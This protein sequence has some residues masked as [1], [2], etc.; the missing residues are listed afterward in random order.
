LNEEL[1]DALEARRGI[2]CAV[3]AGGKKS[4]LYRLAQGHPG[5]VGLTASAHTTFFP[6]TLGLHE[7]I[8]EPAKLAA[9]VAA[10][11][12]QKIGY[13]TPSTRPGRHAGV[14]VE[15]IEHLH[16]FGGFDVTLVKADG[17][18]MRLL[19][20]PA[21]HEPVLPRST[22]TLV[23][24]VSAAAIGRS[25]DESIVHRPDQAAAITGLKNGELIAPAHVARLL[26]SPDGLMKGAAG[27]RVV[28]LINMVDDE[29]TAQLARET[30]E[31]ALDQ[32]TRFDHIVLACMRRRESQVVAVVTR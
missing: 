32:T 31:I 24:V 22:T 12:A 27:M 17:A 26:S 2:I 14:P 6:A 13:A 10:C 19:K 7:I 20:A 8:E 9:A 30:A 3:G 23:T 11:D 28:P 18:R 5:R 4:T 16:E 29:K 1:L 15:M 25:F 21:E